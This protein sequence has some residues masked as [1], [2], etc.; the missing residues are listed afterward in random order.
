MRRRHLLGALALAIGSGHAGNALSQEGFETAAAAARS[1]DDGDYE[2]S[3]AT[4]RQLLDEDSGNLDRAA[5]HYNLGNAEYRTG[6]LGHAMLH[7]E[8]SL[9]IR[10]GDTDA[11]AN[12]ALAR[13]VLDRR[14]TDAAASGDPDTFL[15]ELLGS[16]Q[17]FPVWLRQ[18]PPARF[19]RP[20]SAFVLLAG[21]C[22][23]LL[24]VRRGRRGLLLTVLGLSLVAT[25]ASGIL[26]RLR[27]TVS[28]VAVVVQP[29]AALRSGPG[30]SFPQLAALPEGLYLELDGEGGVAQDGFRRVVAA[31]IVGYADG[32]SVVPVDGRGQAS[33]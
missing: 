7:W 13:S 20:L 30:H 32:E 11:R 33:R 22:W 2:A 16:M 25:T 15:V 12:V 19:A 6:R 21:V 28:P 10:P 5:L 18:T 24:T 29:G 31:G 3:A 1:Y 14:L 9:A 27:L 4:Y 26:L 17:G 8:R 23:T